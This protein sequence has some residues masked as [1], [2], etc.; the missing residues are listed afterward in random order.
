[1]SLKLFFYI[2]ILLIAVF[3]YRSYTATK[4]GLRIGDAAPNFN[5][6]DAKGQPHSLASYAGK[7]TVLYFYPKD[8]TPGCIKEAC[9]FR[10]DLAQLEK[11]GAN[12]VGIS[13]DTSKSHGEFAKKY[14]LPFDLLS[15]PEGKVAKE[16]QALTDLFILKLAKR[17]TFLIDPHGKVAKI[18]R[19]VDVSKHSKQ[20]IDDLIS[21]QRKG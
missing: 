12:V 17:H 16:Y 10:D 8:D 3:G 6:E 18:Y 9:F 1:M 4:N 15:D 14:K 11:L 21:I 13:V 7:Y 20:I 2:T 5:L 19:T